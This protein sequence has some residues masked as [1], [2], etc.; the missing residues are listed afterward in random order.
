VTLEYIDFTTNSNCFD[1]FAHVKS[2]LL[3]GDPEL[4]PDAEISFC[5]PTY[6]RPGLLKDAIKSVLDQN[7][8][9]PYNIV[10]IDNNP[11]FNNTE[12]LEVIKS[13]KKDNIIYYKNEE[14]IS[15]WNRSIFLAKTRW[16]ALLHD[17]DLLE[18]NYLSQVSKVLKKKNS[19]KGLC[20]LSKQINNP[21]EGLFFKKQS[22]ILQKVRSFFLSFK[23]RIN[24]LVKIPL[25]PNMFTNIFG[26]A[27]CG[28]VFD[29]AAFIES[30]GINHITHYTISDHVFC[31]HYSIRHNFYKYKKQ[32]GIYR[33]IGND[34]LR[35][36]IRQDMQNRSAELFFS[37]VRY[38]PFCRFLYLILKRDFD[39]RFAAKADESPRL[40][41]FYYIV[42]GLLTVLY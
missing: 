32:L 15:A 20:V 19:I 8:D 11:D 16:C 1:Q 24:K 35:L 33:W 17:D 18:K 7:T 39:K 41:L 21:F 40:S 2:I 12:T 30:G 22:V 10:I 9:I 6:K 13:L 27:S 38:D 23:N 3:Y 28:M 31:I 34:S 4:L 26:P 5:I 14:E 36:E 37:L 29:R 25:F 42:Y